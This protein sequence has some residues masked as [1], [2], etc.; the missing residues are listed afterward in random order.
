[1]SENK[2]FF[3]DSCVFI[4]YL[5]A[6]DDTP[7]LDD[8]GRFIEDAKA[9]RCT[10]HYS[11]IAFTE[12]RPRYLKNTSY[13]NI[14]EF[15]EDLG[16]NFIPIEPNPNILIAAGELRDAKATNP[17]P[18]EKR[19]RE[20]GTPDAI[21]L[22][23]CVFARDVLGISDIVF[24]TLDEGKGVHWEGKCIPLL[25]IER[26][27]PEATRPERVREVCSLPRMKPMHA[28]PMLTGIAPLERPVGGAPGQPG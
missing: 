7:L 5:A 4:R 9:K 2:N 28:Q 26:W 16:S 27:F 23:S 13:G 21:H 22:M 17:Y 12:I 8:I 19:A 18:K 15:F 3:W 14:N 20:F 24:H 6:P 10:I 25:S 11:P 1:M